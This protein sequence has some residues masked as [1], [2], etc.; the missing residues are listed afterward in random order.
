MAKLVEAAKSG[1]KRAT[2]V[3]LRDK[4]AETIQNCDSGRDMASNSK[5]LME[6]MSE[7][8]QIDAEAEKEH[9]RIEAEKTQKISKHDRLK[10]KY[11]NRQTATDV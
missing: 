9:K 5:R 7:I 8:E 11:E 3:A 4:L 1:D 10:Q 2:L 6:V